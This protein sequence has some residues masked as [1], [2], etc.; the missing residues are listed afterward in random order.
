MK[1]SVAGFVEVSAS[2]EK[3]PCCTVRLSARANAAPAPAPKLTQSTECE[4]DGLAT[5]SPTTTISAANTS[6]GTSTPVARI[7]PA[8]GSDRLAKSRA[9]DDC[10]ASW[11]GGRLRRRALPQR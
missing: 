7:D 4:N 1:A 2:P 9:S 6:T 11:T 10:S 5:S 8:P 3:A